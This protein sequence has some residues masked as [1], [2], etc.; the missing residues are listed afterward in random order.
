[1]GGILAAADADLLHL[2]SLRAHFKRPEK[3]LQNAEI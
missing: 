2:Q 1:V 3:I